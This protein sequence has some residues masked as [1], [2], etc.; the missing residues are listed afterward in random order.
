LCI[1]CIGKPTW[2][3]L[4]NGRAARFRRLTPLSV[5]ISRHRAIKEVD[6]FYLDEGRAT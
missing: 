1:A 6:L 5:D 2:L 4:S 3:W